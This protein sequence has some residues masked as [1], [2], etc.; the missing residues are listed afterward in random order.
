MKECPTHGL[1]KYIFVKSENRKR[2]VKCRSFRTAKRRKA[3]RIEIVRR[4][5]GACSIC[6]Y[7]RCLDAL[8]F[9]HIDPET[10]SFGLSRGRTRSVENMM[11]EAKKCI[12]VCANYH[13]EIE[14][15][16]LLLGGEMVSRRTVNAKVRGSNPLLAAKDLK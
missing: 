4:C 5:G 11:K 7:N 14:S 13:R 6:G 12:L 15:D 16:L 8:E 2:C 10:K 1:T 9:H 3:V